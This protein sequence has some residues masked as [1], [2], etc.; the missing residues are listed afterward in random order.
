MPESGLSHMKV[1]RR[2]VTISSPSESNHNGI[3]LVFRHGPTAKEIHTLDCDRTSFVPSP[4]L[5]A[6][7]WKQ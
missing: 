7:R 5:H 3:Y 2:I 1:E 6:L 4:L